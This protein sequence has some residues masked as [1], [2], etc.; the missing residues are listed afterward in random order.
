MSPFAGVSCSGEK[1]KWGGE[2][3]A[4]ER[5][6]HREFRGREQGAELKGDG[7]LN[8]PVGLRS[9]A[10]DRKKNPHEIL[11]KIEIILIRSDAACQ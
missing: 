4:S 6:E 7:Q 1:K 10:A 5:I 8:E 11:A 9:F 2:G 3:G